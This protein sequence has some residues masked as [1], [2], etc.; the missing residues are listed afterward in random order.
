MTKA[1]L[2]TT[3]TLNAAIDKTYYL[4]AF[5]RDKVSR[6]GKMHAFPG[7]KGLNVA[8]VVRQLG[9]NV[10]ATGY[11]GGFNGEFIKKELDKQGIR[12]DFVTVEGESRLCLNI[13]DESRRTST[14]LLEP[15]PDITA[16]QVEEMKRKVKQLAANSSIVAFSGS[17]PKGVPATIYA[18]LVAIAKAEGAKVFLD[19]SGDPL[20]QALAAKPHF[21]KPN[22]QEIEVILGKKPER[23]SDLHETVRR[24]MAQGIDCVVVSLGAAGSLAGIGGAL[25]RIAAPKLEPV[26]T[27]GCGDAFVAGMAV[28][29]LRGQSAEECLKLATAAGSAN[30]LTEQAG[31]V[32]LSDVE[33]FLQQIVAQRL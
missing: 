14:E 17:I 32:R 24:L 2:I 7:G 30:A 25:Y 9:E 8:R 18:D 31:S 11:V 10:V 27:V 13:I 19:T 21:I 3:V 29:T 16:D 6:V 1:R 5:E 23:E 4:P 26:N 15:G 28:A 12:H 20:L 33:R 22:E